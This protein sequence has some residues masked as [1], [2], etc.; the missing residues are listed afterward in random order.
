MLQNKAM[1]SDRLDRTTD[2]NATDVWTGQKKHYACTSLSFSETE[3]QTAA[4]QVC[5][6]PT[7]KIADAMDMNIVPRQ[8]DLLRV[9][10]EDISQ[11]K[12]EQ[13]L[14]GPTQ[15]APN[16]RHIDDQSLLGSDKIDE[17][18]ER[19]ARYRIRFCK[20]STEFLARDDYHSCFNTYEVD[21]NYVKY[22]EE[23]SKKIKVST[24]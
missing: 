22:C 6:E 2:G 16:I 10:K 1:A 23:I 20:D 7:K 4:E 21:D 8:D 3:V 18:M 14:W 12:D 19:H 17:V 13:E 11:R 5:E 9:S 24:M 15:L